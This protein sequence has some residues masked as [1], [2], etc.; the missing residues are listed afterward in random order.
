MR[1][2]LFFDGNNFFRAFEAAA[3]GV[4]LDYE[5]LAA[6]LVQ[7]IGGPTATLGAA[8]W[9][10]GVA[11]QPGLERFLGGLEQRP[12]YFVVRLPVVRRQW[13]C[14][15][16]ETE[17]EQRVEK[18]VDTRIVADMIGQAHAGAFER[19]VLLSGDEDLVPA[20]DAVQATGRPVWLASWGGAGLSSTLRARAWGHLDLLAGMERFSTGRGRGVELDDTQVLA[21]LR[22]A[23][24]WFDERGG[25]LSRWYFE[26]RWT[27]E[28]V[29]LA[30]G[31][32][33][34]RAVDRLLARGEV[35][36]V[37]AEVNGRKVPALRP[38]TAPGLRTAASADPA[39]R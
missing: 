3:P 1:V 4:E 11:D 28:G 29:D 31:P 22:Q 24:A 9:Y 38:R 37:E 35:E 32:S 12:G 7:A 15:S 33:R 30:L 14:P 34:A 18:Q 27:V 20:L 6:W 17:H 25:Y 26:N 39:S 2:S 19:A 8:T 13:R 10:T 23:V 36:L 16:C 21:F 5:A